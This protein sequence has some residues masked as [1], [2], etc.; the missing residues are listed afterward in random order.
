M[1]VKKVLA[2]VLEESEHY[3]RVVRAAEIRAERG[4]RKRP[5]MGDLFKELV[6]HREAPSRL[7]RIA[8]AAGVDV[9]N[10]SYVDFKVKPKD[11]R[12][13][14]RLTLRRAHE[15]AADDLFETKVRIEHLV[16][17]LFERAAKPKC[18]SVVRKVLL[19]QNLDPVAVLIKVRRGLAALPPKH[20]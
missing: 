12:K 1:M 13:A 16:E 6:L 3:E 5:G 20:S 8:Q 18:R 14:Y 15:L 2:E 4:G 19:R 11:E 17:A 10:L 9:D 7:V